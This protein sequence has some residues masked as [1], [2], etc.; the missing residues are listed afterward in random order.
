MGTK[1]QSYTGGCLCGAV[2]YEGSRPWASAYCHCRM[3]QRAVGGPFWIATQFSKDSF[4]IMRGEPRWFRSSEIADRGFCGECGTPLFVQYRTA[5]WSDWIGVSTGSLDDPAAVAP[6]RHLG[7][8]SR[9]PWLAMA[10]DLP[11]E[12]Y[13]ERFLEERAEYDRQNPDQPP[14]GWRWGEETR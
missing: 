10:D 8:E 3:C 12:S 5:E 2:R 14:S 4:Q 7:V 6:E 1:S 11:E 9:V 13:P